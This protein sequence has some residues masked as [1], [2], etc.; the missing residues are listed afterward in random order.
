VTLSH[1]GIMLFDFSK[2][3][4]RIL[5]NNLSFPEPNHLKF[6]QKVR[7][8]QRQTKMDFALFPLFLELKK[9]HISDFFS[10]T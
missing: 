6:I 9:I 3:F 4:L 2:K 10:I 7:D 5:F 8:H 1:S